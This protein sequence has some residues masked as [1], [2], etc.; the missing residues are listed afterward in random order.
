[1][2]LDEKVLQAVDSVSTHPLH[3]S[4]RHT[5]EELIAQLR[6][7]RTARQLYLLQK[8]LLSEVQQAENKQQQAEDYLQ[9]LGTLRRSI[10]ERT[11]DSGSLDKAK[12]RSL[13]QRQNEYRH[14][15]E[16]FKQVR[17]ELRSV[18]DGLL[19]TA[20]NFNRGYILGISDAPKGGNEHLSE[21]E[22]LEA[23]LDVLEY[24]WRT[25]EALAI[26][27]DL[28]NCGRVGDLTVLA[29]GETIKT[30]EVKKSSDS[31]SSKRAM[32]QSS[33]M[34]DMLRFVR[35]KTV[36]DKDGSTTH[37][38][39]IEAPL[40]NHLGAYA[41]VLFE[42]GTKGVSG[43]VVE[44]YLGL[45]AFYSLHQ[46]WDLIGEA[47][48][49][50]E[51]REEA[52]E[53]AVIAGHEPLEGIIIKEGATVHRWDS[54]EKEFSMM[55]NG[56]S[57][58]PFSIYPFHPELCAAL[59]CGYLRLFVYI[60]LE[61]LA[62]RFRAAG[63]GTEIEYQ[64]AATTE[65]FF[66]VIHLSKSKLNEDGTRDIS[67]ISLGRRLHQQIIGEGMTF[68]TLLK[69]IVEPAFED[70]AGEG[71]PEV[72]S[73]DFNYTQEWLTWTEL[74]QDCYLQARDLRPT[75]YNLY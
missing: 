69:N 70:S 67:Y 60:N 72:D 43:A 18:G 9:E 63:Y 4:N 65:Q 20:T 24:L 39:T 30:Y 75:N 68:D 71:D 36:T 5:I 33:R 28:T 23:E 47:N 27:H 21:P 38:K 74:H 26:L 3:R 31:T 46:R 48:V 32:R 29:P 49:S 42:A 2:L 1:M 61:A 25:K 10:T 62:D 44:D 55:D 6:V 66:T 56:T 54:I 73:S 64:P 59:V 12:L 13:Q 35:G 17:R 53:Q 41:R 7:S 8:R 22:G 19:W 52:N 16:V 57:G 58:A 40:A 34:K 37:L 15:I 45:V 14:E 51:A 11:K 50:E